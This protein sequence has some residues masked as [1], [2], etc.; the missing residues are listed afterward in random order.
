MKAPNHFL[1]KVKKTEQKIFLALRNVYPQYIQW[2]E[3]W[4]RENP[5]RFFLSNFNANIFFGHNSLIIFKEAK[6]LGAELNRSANR[7]FNNV[8]VRFEFVQ[9]AWIPTCCLPQA[10]DKVPLG[11]LRFP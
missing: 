1:L 9:R 4:S 3:G 6:V 2:V 10:V 11:S 7:Y 5:K 8:L